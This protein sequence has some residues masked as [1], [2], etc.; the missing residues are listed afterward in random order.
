MHKL[1]YNEVTGVALESV[2]FLFIPFVICGFIL[3]WIYT[4]LL[5]SGMGRR[6]DEQRT[7]FCS[8]VLKASEQVCA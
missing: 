3:H 8:E 2:S 4:V 5:V 7:S 6:D 1:L